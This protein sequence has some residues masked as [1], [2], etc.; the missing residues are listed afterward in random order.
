MDMGPY[1]SSIPRLFNLKKILK[2]TIRIKKNRDKLI[3][4]IKFL[5]K[6]EEGDYDGNFKF[7][8][9]YKNEIKI[10]NKKKKY[11]IHRAFSPPDNEN[12]II[13]ANFKSLCFNSCKC[14]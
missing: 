11:S 2:K 13:K 8:G 14:S 5:L 4:S 9:E 12:L 7:G 3:T 1:I 10:T 6:F